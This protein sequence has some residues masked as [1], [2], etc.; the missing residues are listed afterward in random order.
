M[1]L[2]VFIQYYLLSH[3]F[4]SKPG[5]FPSSWLFLSLQ[6]FLDPG[7]FAALRIQPHHPLATISQWPQ[8][9]T[10]DFSALD[11]STWQPSYFF[12]SFITKHSVEQVGSISYRPTHFYQF[13]KIVN[14]GTNTCTKSREQLTSF[15]GIFPEWALCALQA[16]GSHL[17]LF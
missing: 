13:L 6:W 3:I 14:H 5:F 2:N 11:L 4:S 8:M 10:H 7:H 9:I 17:G 1:Y 16:L 12:T 15:I